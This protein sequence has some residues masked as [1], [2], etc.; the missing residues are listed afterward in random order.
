[1]LSLSAPCSAR[2]AIL[3]IQPFQ[4]FSINS[5]PALG[6]KLA[7]LLAYRCSQVPGIR[8]SFKQPK[9]G[10]FH[11][12]HS[13]LRINRA[14][15]ELRVRVFHKTE[16]I[17]G[18]RFL[19]KAVA[20]EGIYGLLE[21]AAHK[22]IDGLPGSYPFRASKPLDIAFF[23]DISGSMYRF[24]PDL[25]RGMLETL[26]A[27]ERTIP[28]TS[29]RKAVVLVRSGKVFRRTGLTTSRYP[30]LRN[31]RDLNAWSR[32]VEVRTLSGVIYREICTLAWRRDALKALVLFTNR[33]GSAYL[34]SLGI[35]L[36][37]QGIRLIIPIPADTG[38]EAASVLAELARSNRG[39]AF[40]APVLINWLSD[41][42]QG[43]FLWER[44]SIY[45]FRA[46][47]SNSRIPF[48]R[49][50]LMRHDKGARIFRAT[51]LRE[52]LRIASGNR[53]SRII[54][55]GTAFARSVL[56]G[57]RKLSYRR[58]IRVQSDLPAGKLLLDSGGLRFWA[59]ITDLRLFRKIR[60]Y[61]R[62]GS[63]WLGVHPVPAPHKR[64]GFLLHPGLFILPAPGRRIPELAQVDAARLRRRVKF[65]SRT[66]IFS[67]PR[68]FIRVRLLKSRRYRLSAPSLER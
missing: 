62:T 3:Q 47:V 54:Q 44:G 53:N 26:N 42:K 63:F 8:A 25:Q 5:Y 51:T 59:E 31:L 14:G 56:Q 45:R 43:A 20:L 48:I 16:Q 38:E 64:L 18:K 32:P 10:R 65:Y 23:L 41:R 2:G 27:L 68:W 11:R 67:P 55:A 49:P 50:S 39:V 19:I 52:A 57:L 7:Y 30:I 13:R 58:G 12:I 35:R 9:S 34:H 6:K 61:R 46:P 29:I 60:N 66:G 15:L 40:T 17:A 1:M 28:T 22:I 24:V 21:T 36:A 37:R 4:V 33:P